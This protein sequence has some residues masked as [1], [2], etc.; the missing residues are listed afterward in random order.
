MRPRRAPGH[1]GPRARSELSLRLGSTVRAVRGVQALIGEQ[2]SF[3]RLSVHD[4]GLDD[5]VDVGDTAVPDLVRIDDNGGAVLALI[6]APGHVGT[7]A[8][9]ETTQG[10]LLFEKELKLG[11]AGGIAATAG[12]ARLAPIAAD[13][14]VL[15]ELGHSPLYRSNRF[16]SEWCVAN[17]GRPWP[18]PVSK[19]TPGT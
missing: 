12:M 7:H 1:G 17:T 2:Q 13:K 19:G 9:L 3:D 8:L 10:E 4:V 15:F 11:L 5:L 6:E 18:W 16:R 14:Q